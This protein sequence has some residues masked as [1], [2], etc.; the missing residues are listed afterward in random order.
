MSELS[1]AQPP[2]W[3]WRW[4]GDRVTGALLGQFKV[5]GWLFIFLAIVIGVPDWHSRYEFW[6]GVAKST[7]GYMSPVAT[8]LLWP[9]F[10]VALGSVGVLYLLAVGHPKHAP[11]RYPIIPVVGWIC[12]AACFA[13]VIVT[14]G[15][16]A[17]EIYIRTEIARGI[18]GVPRGTPD[19]NNPNRP[20]RPLL[21]NTDAYNLTPDQV[22]ILIQ[23]IP[24]LKPLIRI[25][26]FSRAPNDVGPAFSLWLRFQDVFIRSGIPPALIN[27][28]PRGPEEEGLMI[29]VRNPTQ[30]PLAAQKLI[31]AFEIANIRLR[32][33][34]MPSGIVP[35]DIEF[36]VFL[37]PPPIRWN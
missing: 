1:P 21:A 2:R 9:Y 28:D 12:F 37:G 3:S 30:I 13:A 25:A 24:K 8:I 10:P 11:Q 22:R 7:G 32:P 14:A 20:Q 15:Y 4:L 18:A 6:L 26:Y 23:E 36:V 16:G 33:I 35:P 19:E 34:Q 27:E 17:A 5:P 29:A 31:E